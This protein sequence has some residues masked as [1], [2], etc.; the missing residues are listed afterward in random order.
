MPASNKPGLFGALRAT[1]N[2]AGAVESRRRPHVADLQALGIDKA[3][4]AN[5]YF[6]GPTQ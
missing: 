6:R 4:A 2:V 1:V 5:R 3:F